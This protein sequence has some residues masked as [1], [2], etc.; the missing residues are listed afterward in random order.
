MTDAQFA[1][2]QQQLVSLNHTNWQ[3]L[4]NLNALHDTANNLL[5][6]SQILLLC[7]NVIIGLLIGGFLGLCL[8]FWVH[9]P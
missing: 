1:Q 5:G 2:L 4:S 8:Y 6:T 9:R 3:I 7:A